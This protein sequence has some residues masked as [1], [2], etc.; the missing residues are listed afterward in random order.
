MRGFQDV[1]MV[2]T[3]QVAMTV[4]LSGEQFMRKPC[5]EPDPHKPLKF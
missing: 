3:V 1:T 4:E 5:S 2:Q